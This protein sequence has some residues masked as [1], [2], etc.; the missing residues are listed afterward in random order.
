LV[1]K[2]PKTMEE[3]RTPVTFKYCDDSDSLHTYFTEKIMN[4]L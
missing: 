3:L 1:G 4:R 2:V